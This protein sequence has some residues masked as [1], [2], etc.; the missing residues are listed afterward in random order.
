MRH[1]QMYFKTSSSPESTASPAVLPRAAKA[2]TLATPIMNVTSKHVAIKAVLL[3]VTDSIA[4]NSKLNST[5]PSLRATNP[6]NTSAKR[7]NK[8]WTKYAIPN[9]IIMGANTARAIARSTIFP[10]PDSP[11]PLRLATIWVVLPILPRVRPRD[12]LH[13]LERSDLLKVSP[14]SLRDIRRL[15]CCR[16]SKFD[17]LDSSRNCSSIDCGSAIPS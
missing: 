1:K 11:L 12:P 6:I 8:T 10:R 2:T 17:R 5:E 14:L 4:L 9:G 7:P 15:D 13:S 3:M 16:R